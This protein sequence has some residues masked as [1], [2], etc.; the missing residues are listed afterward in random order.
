VNSIP[1]LQ[2]IFQTQIAKKS[3]IEP[4]AK[5]IVICSDFNKGY[6]PDQIDYRLCVFKHSNLSIRD[7]FS[8]LFQNRFWVLAMFKNQVQ[9]ELIQYLLTIF[10]M[11]W[12]QHHKVQGDFYLKKSFFIGPFSEGIIT[13]IANLH[14]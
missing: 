7:W 8:T 1:V 5:L 12:L 9:K 6:Y 10:N 3:T 13:E 4:L 2:V 14:P 11:A